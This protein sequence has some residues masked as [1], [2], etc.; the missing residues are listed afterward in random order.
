MICVADNGPGI[1]SEHLTQIFEPF[2]TTRN[3]GLG[4]G[5]SISRRIV[6]LHGGKLVGHSEL[7]SGSRF[8]FSVPLHVEVLETEDA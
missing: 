5:L 1:A 2:Y 3:E 7:G 4:M 8:E 6:E